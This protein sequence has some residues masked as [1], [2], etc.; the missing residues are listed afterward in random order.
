MG[1]GL[2]FCQDIGI[3]WADSPPNLTTDI[4]WSDSGGSG[5]RARYGGVTDIEQAFN[6]ARRAE[7]LQL[8]LSI[9]QLGLLQLPAQAVWDTLDDGQKALTLINAE[10]MARTAMLPNVLGL[11]LAGIEA[12]L[13]NTAST[14]ADLLITSNTF[15][16]F[17]PSNNPA[18]DNPQIRIHNTP[19][20]KDCVQ[21]LSRAENLA[22][23]WSSEALIPLPIER[24]I[25]G[26]IYVDTVGLWG[27]REA[28]LLQDKAVDGTATGFADDLGSNAH[29][30]FLGIGHGGA[31]GYNPF[32]LNFATYGEVVV[33]NLIDPAPD[34]GCPTDAGSGQITLALT[35]PADLV[36]EVGQTFTVTLHLT[37]TGATVLTHL[38]LTESYASGN[39]ALLSSSLEPAASD[40]TNG[41]L[42]WQQVERVLPAELMNPGDSLSLSLQL[43]ALTPTLPSIPAVVAMRGSALEGV[44]QTA[45]QTLD[46]RIVEA[47]N[48]PFFTAT[49]I[50][51]PLVATYR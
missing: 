21:F 44:D 1:L 16:H 22:G 25:Y 41:W 46:I 38:T 51:L 37:N 49:S 39:L 43:R 32:N 50:Y 2:L 12:N 34:P 24:A 26:W 33:M 4:P 11:P 6:A 15:G 30:G 19:V 3:A 36:V 29:E 10:R 48:P 5:A 28:V 8:G 27:H 20:I 47:I 13:D 45:P 9:N 18:V 7:E 35:G 17:Q 23:F 42:V 14:Y 31:N 40:P